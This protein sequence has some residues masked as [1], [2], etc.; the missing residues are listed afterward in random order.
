MSVNKKYLIILDIDGTLLNSDG[1]ITDLTKNILLKLQSLGHKLVLASGRSFYRLQ[2]IAAELEMVKYGGYFVE[3]NGNCLYD[4]ANDN[5]IRLFSLDIEQLNYICSVLPNDIEL[6]FNGDCQLFHIIP[7]EIFKL[8]TL[9][10]KEM[11]LLDNYPWSSGAYSWFSD[12]SD[13]Y[14]TSQV[15]SSLSDIDC[16]I[17]K[18]TLSQNADYIDKFYPLLKVKLQDKF[19][20]ALIS[21]RQ[22]EITHINANKGL[23]LERLIK[24][25]GLSRYKTIA[26]GDSGNDLDLIGRVDVFVA[27]GN[28]LE[29]VHDR[30]D[31][32][33]D[34][35]DSDGIYKFL[36]AYIKEG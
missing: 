27:M 20:V 22:I 10:R 16:V 9:I 18:M 36:K 1:K 33:T 8:K 34:S 28:C 17:N 7:N 25:F 23:G 4:V 30:A 15:I 6:T 2:K 31:F 5:R 21:R 11:K 35:H 24:H 3:I 29:I 13:G 26:F 19:Q 14:F 12:L 32:V